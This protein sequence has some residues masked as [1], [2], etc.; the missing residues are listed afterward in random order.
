[1]P[2]SYETREYWNHRF[3][4]EREQPF[5]W[6]LP[7]PVVRDVLHE[8]VIT[9]LD[10]GRDHQEPVQS[11]PKL[12]HI[13]CGTSPLSHALQ[14]IV[15]DSSQVVNVDY[16][17]TAIEAG[18]EW[19]RR[20][21]GGA[22][23]NG[24]QWRQADL[25]SSQGVVPALS[26]IPHEVVASSQHIVIVDKATSDSIACCDD[27]AVP[28]PYP[29]TTHDPTVPANQP[30]QS[31][32]METAIHPLHV[33]AVNLASLT[34]PGRGNWLVISY[35]DDR[36]PFFP[37][38]PRTHREGLLADNVLEKGFPHPAEL[39]ELERKWTVDASNEAI[40][41]DSSNGGVVHRPEIKYWVYVL[42]R[43]ERPLYWRGGSQW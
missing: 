14:E 39:W 34:P 23:A 13:G 31:G 36:F 37:P 32:E 10:S 24:M 27:V 17:S 7:A 1:M 21:K 29:L 33:L 22:T 6:L 20:K 26:D 11:K 15:E 16:S 25:L 28:L 19:E 35:C 41:D 38:L 40:D 30:F 3:A 18:L 42:R 4:R 43:T 5:D 9:K 2:P 12:V 8:E